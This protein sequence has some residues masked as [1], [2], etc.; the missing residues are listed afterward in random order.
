VFE[1]PL[2][3]ALDGDGLIELRAAG[4]IDMP[5]LE[6]RTVSES[7][8][9]ATVLG[10]GDVPTGGDVSPNGALVAL[11]TYEAVWLWPREPG[12]SVAEAFRN[13]P[14]QV[15]SVPEPQGEA[16]TFLDDGLVTVGEGVN[17]PLNRLGK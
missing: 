2:E 14:C 6:T 9:P 3:G 7:P 4:S 15:M 13:E 8:H 1:G 10:F 16:V 5:Q 12:Q 17:P 11:R